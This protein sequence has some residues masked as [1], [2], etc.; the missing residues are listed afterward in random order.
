MIVSDEQLVAIWRAKAR[1]PLPFFH[2]QDA[3]LYFENEDE[4]LS[5][6]EV[7]R[8][9]LMLQPETRANATHHVLAYRADIMSADENQSE[10]SDT[11]VD[12]DDIWRSVQPNVLMAL[13][14]WDVGDSA[15]KSKFVLV[16]GECGWE[17]EHGIL[18]SWRDGTKLVRVSDY[19]GHATNGHAFN[20]LSK[21]ACVYYS[22]L[23]GMST[24]R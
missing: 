10:V 15:R 5:F 7:L 14:S 21:D 16:E 13:E 18:F 2:G 19:D 4:L 6:A 11:V 22:L 23:P 3:E 9:F 17:P 12:S 1:I 24:S 20:N 8:N